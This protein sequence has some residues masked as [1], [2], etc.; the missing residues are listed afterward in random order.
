MLSTSVRHRRVGSAC[1]TVA[2][3]FLAMSSVHAQWVNFVDETTSRLVASPG[4]GLTDTEEKDYIW[5]DVDQD[6]DIDLVCV[7]KEPFTT[8]GREPN[9]LFMNEGVAEG[10]PINGVLVDKTSTYVASSDVPGDQGF[11]TATNDRDVQFGDFNNDGWL[12]MVTAVTLSDNQPKA[13]KMPRIYINLGNDAGGNWLGYQH[14]DAWIPDLSIGTSNVNSSPR[15]CAVGVIDINDDG[16]DDLYFG[17]Y[18]AQGAGANVP[19]LHDYND[20][21]LINIGGS[22]VDQTSLMFLNM[23]QPTGAPAQPFPQSTFSASVAVA[24]MNNDGKDDL[25]K[26]SSLQD[27]R[28]VAISYHNPPTD[29]FET[30]DEVYNL[31]AYFVSAGDLNNDGLNDLVIVD[32]FTDRIM[33]NQGIVNGVATWDTNNDGSDDSFNLQGSTSE[34]G[35]NSVIADLDN[36]GWNDVLVADVDVDIPGCARRLHIFRNLADPPINTLAEQGGAQPWTPQGVHDVAVF[37]LNG[38]GWLDMILGTCNGTEIWINDPPV[39][40]TYTYPL[41][42][43]GLATPNTPLTLQVELLAAGSTI[44]PGTVQLN[45]SQDGAPY[46]QEVLSEI[47]TNLYD[48]TLPSAPCGTTFDFFISADLAIGG[49]FNDPSTAGANPYRITISEVGAQ[50]VSENFETGSAGWTIENDASLTTGAWERLIPVGTTIA[51]QPS[52]PSED[53]GAGGDQ[54]AMVTQNGTPGGTAG[55]ADV[56]G[57]PTRLISPTFDLSAGDGLV[58][59]D[60]WF[61]SAISATNYAAG[62]DTLGVAISNA[63]GAVGTWVSVDTFTHT[64]GQWRNYSFTASEFVT[65]TATMQVRFTV[66]DTS[67]GSITEAGLDNFDVTFIGCLT[68]DP[69]FARGDVN[70]D[71]S[72]DISDPV[73]LLN[74]L[75]SAGAISCESS[76]DANDD[77]AINIA[78]VVRMLDSLFGVGGPL[79]GPSVCGVDPTTDTLTCDNFPAC[80]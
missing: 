24:D 60:Y 64:T 41:G 77:G 25:I 7:R 1:L 21:A 33:F 11:L 13:I 14:Q 47:S 38:D 22:F 2:L 65:P 16:L 69:V 29:K 30:H 26:Q 71:G 51:G 37:D 78:D 9:V 43:P 18:D 32:D 48:F 15:F 72:K 27:P 80:P 20:R 39:G 79:P 74:H 45:Y 70:V 66:A 5:G 12:D 55:A 10:H 17:D 19:M 49:T 67:P 50:L 3:L 59:F 58:T 44:V 68:T 62:N 23:L 57:G 28:F 53:A 46:Q 42:I 8:I 31:A 56:D 35:G 4:L 36:D 63:G 34:F 76:A 73:S 52:A 75:F 40:V 61:I 54:F 6:G